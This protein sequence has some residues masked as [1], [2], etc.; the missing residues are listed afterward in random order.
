MIQ[1]KLLYF[2]QAT[3]GSTSLQR[4]NSL[5]ECFSTTYIIDSRRVM[6]DKP[7]RSFFK[8]VQGRVGFGPILSES[9]NILIQEC[10]RFN[11]DILW[12]DGGYFVSDSTIN[13]LKED[14]IMC[15]HYTPDS[16]LAPGLSNRCFK[17]AIKSY[18]FLVT[19]KKQDL[20]MYKKHSATNLIFSF[21]GFDPSI[22]KEEE[23]VEEKYSSDVV[24]VGQCMKE[25]MEY[26]D[27]LNN[28]LK[29]NLKIFGP[30]WDEATL[31]KG[32]NSKCFGPVIHS[33]YAKVLSGSKIALGFLNTEVKDQFTTR[34]FEIPSCGPLLIAPRTDEHLEIFEEDK[35]AVFFSNKE[36][37]LDKISFY[38]SN[39]EKRDAIAIQGKSK[40]LNGMFTWTDL[41]RK[42]LKDMKIH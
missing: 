30:G 39:P 6:P 8:S 16:I 28:N 23:G 26:L 18:D 27:Y 14:G 1:K 7:Y 32:L 40:V 4:Y 38:L 24:F 11:P 19:T 17:R 37:F 2:G 9:R 35:E 34:S 33:D 29:C 20:S 5:K 36:E 13:K 31:P 42:N 3:W 25:R 41:I 15:V 22:H 21:Q 12:V 10:K